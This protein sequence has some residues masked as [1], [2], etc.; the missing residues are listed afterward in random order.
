M[1]A[2]TVCSDFGA[3]EEEIYHCFHLSTSICHAVMGLDAMILVC[4]FCFF[5]KYLVLSWLFHFPPSLSSRGS[6]APLHFP[7]LGIIHMSEV[8]DVSPT[9]LDS[10][11]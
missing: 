11:L 8:V 1:G 2:V 3:Q 10:S 6:L 4:F 9:Y 5:F 7:P